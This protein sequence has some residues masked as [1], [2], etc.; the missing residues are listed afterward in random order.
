MKKL[1]KRIAI[2]LIFS[3][4]FGSTLWALPTG[5]QILAAIDKQQEMS[6]DI[7]AKVKI[8]QQKVDQGVRI[9]KCVFYRRDRDDAFLVVMTAPDNEKGNG[10][11]SDQELLAGRPELLGDEG[12]VDVYED[13][14]LNRTSVGRLAR[15]AIG[16]GRVEG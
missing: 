9:L 2:K 15:Q 10:Y 11:L 14:R 12:P 8:T 7:T 16:D 4:L 6:T 13:G 3:F 5:S 1:Y